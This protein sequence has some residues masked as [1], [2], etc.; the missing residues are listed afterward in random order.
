[1]GQMGVMLLWYQIFMRDNGDRE[2]FPLGDSHLAH[3]QSLFVQKTKLQQRAVHLY[4]QCAFEGES[5]PF[6]FGDASNATSDV[7]VT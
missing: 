4:N 2:G 6:P 7:S 3:R 1:M 5:L